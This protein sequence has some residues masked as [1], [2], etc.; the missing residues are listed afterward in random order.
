MPSSSIALSSPLS[1]SSTDSLMD[2]N[3]TN[4]ENKKPKMV[5][6]PENSHLINSQQ[7]INNNQ[8]LKICQ[9][10][11]PH[12]GPLMSVSH[13]Q[14]ICRNLMKENPDFILLTGDYFTVLGNV[15]GYLE[16]ALS[17]LKSIHDRCFACLGNH[18]ME[19][20]AVLQRTIRELN[21]LGI[22]LLRNEAIE[23]DS[24]IGKIQI[25]G[26]DYIPFTNLSRGDRIRAVV[27]N[28]QP[29]VECKN[30]RIVLLHDPGAFNDFVGDESIIAFSGH[31][32]GGHVGF[33]SCGIR[34]TLVA[35]FTRMP[36]NGLW[37]KGKNLVYVHRGQGSRALVT[38]Y[39]LRVG[40]PSEQSS[41]Q[42]QW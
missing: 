30:R 18:D 6:C 33:L 24:R 25:I 37:R 40:V 14:T 27:N 9:I 39:V 28:N 35:A 16:E 26:Y 8:T 21:N 17:P 3:H 13:L 7:N 42:I 11:D 12:I 41:V 20:D 36:D 19:S 29:S 38:N 2:N 4:G 31:T 1:T 22:K 15:D 32:H 5:K 23:V 10:T 34:F